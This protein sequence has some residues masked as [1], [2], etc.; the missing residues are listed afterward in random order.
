MK[1]SIRQKARNGGQVFALPKEYGFLNYLRCHDDIGWG[2]DYGFLAR[3]GME[4]IAHKKYLN[5]YLTGRWPGSPARGELYND[6][7]RLGDARLCG[8][9]A[10]LCGVEAARRAGDG[11]ALA[12]ALRLDLMLHAYIFTLSGIPVLYS[13]DEIARENDAGYHDD[14]LKAADSRY[15]HRGAMDWAAAE[16]RGDPASPEGTVFQ[17]L[18]R[19]ERL[20]AAHRVF[21]GAADT[22]IVDTGDDG[23][24]G[25]GRYHR[26]E[27]L[28]ALFNFS[29]EE[30]TVSVREEG[31]Y[32]DLLR[33]GS[34]DPGAV[35]L[36]PGGFAL[37]LCEFE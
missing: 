32:T 20:R 6:D 31:D 1:N 14:P 18:R 19:L 9:T 3:F 27:K 2:L 22:W 4:E 11:A 21:D 23:V 24:P 7:P 12:R 29:G 15:L 36:E 28:V 17:G 16:R 5:D 25:L 13:G 10:S 30:K 37:L 33:G 26:G 35:T 34:A 8:T